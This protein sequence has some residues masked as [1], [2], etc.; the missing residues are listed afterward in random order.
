MIWEEIIHYFDVGGWT[1]LCSGDNGDGDCEVT[2]VV[3][4]MV[5][6]SDFTPER[7]EYDD[8][9]KYCSQMACFVSYRLFDSYTVLFTLFPSL[10]R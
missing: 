9:L 10:C 2:V 3:V 1:D 6:I 7:E 4:T 8:D 5:I